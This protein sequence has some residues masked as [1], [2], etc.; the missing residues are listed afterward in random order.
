MEKRLN[1]LFLPP[2]VREMYTARL[3]L[4]DPTSR[5]WAPR[6][7]ARNARGLRSRPWRLLCKRLAPLRRRACGG[8]AA[9]TERDGI[10]SK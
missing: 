1:V 7:C 9:C 6:G 4:I 3:A 10:E 8:Y 5:V 2:R